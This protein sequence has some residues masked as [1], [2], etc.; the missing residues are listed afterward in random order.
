MPITRE[1][2]AKEG[3]WKSQP[4]RQASKV[5]LIQAC[6]GGR[7]SEGGR[8]L[9]SSGQSLPQS[10]AACMLHAQSQGAIDNSP[11]GTTVTGGDEGDCLSHVCPKR[12]DNRG[13]YLLLMPDRLRKKVPG[14]HDLHLPH[15]GLTSSVPLCACVRLLVGGWGGDYGGLWDGE[16]CSLCGVTAPLPGSATLDDGHLA[17]RVQVGSPVTMRGSAAA[18]TAR[19]RLEKISWF[20]KKICRCAPSSWTERMSQQRQTMLVPETA[21]R[22][23]CLISDFPAVLVAEETR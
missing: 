23:P 12:V 11:V 6:Q 19:K 3:H 8:D 14:A 16:D 15:Q 18:I 20:G 2:E 7:H 17:S 10:P 9:G 22:D 5:F 1:Q 4:Q 21:S 13:L